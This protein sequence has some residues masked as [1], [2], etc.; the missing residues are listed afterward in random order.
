MLIAAVLVLVAIALTGTVA[1]VG[2]RRARGHGVAPY[3][4][5]SQEPAA[6]E[7]PVAAGPVY[8]LVTPGPGFAPQPVT[9]GP[10]EGAP[11][12]PDVTSRPERRMASA[13]RGAH[14]RGSD[15]REL[16]R[17]EVLHKAGEL[18]HDELVSL[19]A[20]LSI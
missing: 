9:L 16:A 5:D 12:R 1:R 6:V 17:L 11:H 13:R 3:A 7:A 20:R 19:K 18:S 10:S 14:R 4:A 8:G 2:P 15:A